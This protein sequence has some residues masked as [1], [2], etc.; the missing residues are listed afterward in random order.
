MKEAA[1]ILFERELKIRNYSPRTVQ[2][3]TICLNEYFNF[4]EKYKKDERIFDEEDAKNFLLYK[5]E[6]NCSPSTLNVY[7]CSIKFYYKEIEKL[8]QKIDIKFARR[9]KRL[10]VVLANHEIMDIIR[11]LQNLK[12]KL[13]L[14]LAYG[15]GLRVSE[16]VNLKIGDLDFNSRTILVRQGKGCKDRITLLPEALSD[17]LR[18][19]I[20]GSRLGVESRDAKVGEQK[21][22]FRS[23]RGG[24][25]TTRTLQ[26]VFRNAL[27][28]IGISKQASFHSLRHSFATHL[29]EDGVNLRFIQELLGHQNIRTTQ[30]YTHVSREAL[31]RNVRS[32]FD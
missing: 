31:L 17:D 12:H 16:V 21:W 19:F 11:S 24:K 15:A 4:L 2:S 26:K 32:P 13:A 1:L 23:Q 7:L 10:P 22:L 25:L 3:Y 28:K 9:N 29:I 5:K 27:I 8:Y 30:L 18:E 6:Q 14:S 20:A